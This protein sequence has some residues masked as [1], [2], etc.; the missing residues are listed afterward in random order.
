MIPIPINNLRDLAQTYRASGVLAI[1][2]GDGK[3][4]T[5][6]YGMT[7]EKCDA[8]KRVNIRI[9]EL[10]ENGTIEIPEELT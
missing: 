3:F 9:A 5:T 4:A 7:R 2:F 6:S 8:L 1:Q 10:I